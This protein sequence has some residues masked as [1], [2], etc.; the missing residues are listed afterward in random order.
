MLCVGVNA[1][2]LATHY[3]R[4]TSVC[5]F[6]PLYGYKQCAQNTFYKEL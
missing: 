5:G 6:F 4:V 2:I 1:P 3:P